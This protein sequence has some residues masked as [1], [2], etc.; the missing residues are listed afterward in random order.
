MALSSSESSKASVL[1]FFALILPPATSSTVERPNVPNV[2][3]QTTISGRS[4][5]L[6]RPLRI[7]MTC[8]KMHCSGVEINS[9]RLASSLGKGASL[10]APNVEQVIAKAHQNHD[11]RYRTIFACFYC[12]LHSRQPSNKKPFNQE[13]IDTNLTKRY[14]IARKTYVLINLRLI[15]CMHPHSQR[16]RLSINLSCLTRHSAS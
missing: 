12:S 1:T 2:L 5:K 16:Q 8:F 14:D 7:G 4:E 15:T 9:G 3:P 13:K 11:I 10:T 6:R